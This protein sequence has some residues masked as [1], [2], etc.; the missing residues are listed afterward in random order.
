M[1]CRRSG[2]L[3]GWQ[4]KVK[5]SW[6]IQTDD[7]VVIRGHGGA[8]ILTRGTVARTVALALETR[9]G[10]VPVSGEGRG[11]IWRFPLPDGGEGILRESCR[12][13]WIGRLLRRHY[14]MVNRPRREWDVHYRAWRLGLPTVEP[15]GVRWV[16]RGPLCTGMLA[17][18]YAEGWSLVRWVEM[19]PDAAA[20]RDGLC[21]VG[22]AVRRIHDAGFLHVDLQ[23]RN[24][25]ITPAGTVLLLDWD[26]GRDLGRPA[27]AAER[28]HGLFRFRRSLEKAGWSPDLFTAFLEGY[29]SFQ[30]VWRVERMWA[31]KRLVAPR[32]GKTE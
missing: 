9:A 6:E 31:L 27:T 20:R 19:T 32:H 10:C 8:W 2:G 21:R 14:L 3:R 7:T 28:S 1:P 16:W 26:R 17:T 23:V 13:G 30:P 12:G 25:L 11:A 24:I 4:D 15:L 18:R 22:A 29:G 5:V